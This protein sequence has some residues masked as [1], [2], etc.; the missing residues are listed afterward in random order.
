MP[1]ITPIVKGTKYNSLTIIQEVE[2]ILNKKG[3]KLRRVKCLCDCGNIKDYYYSNIKSNLTT[4]CGC[5]RNKNVKNSATKYSDDYILNKK[6]NKWTVLN[7]E[8]S[9]TY[10]KDK[11][12]VSRRMF[13]CK[14]DCGKIKIIDARSLIQGNSSSCGCYRD[15]LKFLKRKHLD[16]DKNSE[17]YWLYYTWN[18]MIGRCHNQNSKRYYRY[19][20]RGIEVYSEWHNYINFKEWILNNIGIRPEKHSLD[21]INNDGNY[22]PNNVKWSTISEQA[23]NRVKKYTTVKSK[24]FKILPYHVPKISFINEGGCTFSL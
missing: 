14:C 5:V 12:F 1:S 17:F 3:I 24:K 19:G 13:K 6:F 9:K 16:A 11:V 15:E 20:G 8:K 18:S 7:I 10:K 2:P 23:N 4:S 21:R 22:E